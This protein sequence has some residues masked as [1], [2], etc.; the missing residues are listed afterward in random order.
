MGKVNLVKVLSVPRKWNSR[1]N[2]FDISQ[3][4]SKRDIS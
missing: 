1:E 4:Q 3:I 2:E